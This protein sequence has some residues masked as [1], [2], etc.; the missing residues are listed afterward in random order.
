[1]QPPPISEQFQAISEHFHHSAKK[2]GTLSPGPAARPP[3][4]RPQI[5]LRPH[6]PARPRHRASTGPDEDRPSLPLAPPPSVSV[7]PALAPRPA[8]GVRSRSLRGPT[9]VPHSAA[10]GGC[11]S[12]LGTFADYLGSQ[13]GSRADRRGASHESGLGGQGTG[14]DWPLR[15][16][17]L[18]ASSEPLQSTLRKQS[19]AVGAGHASTL[20]QR[21]VAGVVLA[22]PRTSAARDQGGDMPAM[23]GTRSPEL[24]PDERRASA[25]L[26]SR[27]PLS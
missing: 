7:R 19:L 24:C 3:G 17:S 10:K 15:A 20:V 11:F 5:S 4:L 16:A 6:R 22:T 14:L 26:W 2:P 9:L 18:W 25:P 23:V 21:A 1:M 12:C 27:W 8:D 13:T